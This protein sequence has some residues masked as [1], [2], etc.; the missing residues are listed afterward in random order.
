MSVGVLEA[1]NR[2][3]DDQPLDPV[4]PP[5]IVITQQPGAQTITSGQKAT[6]AVVAEGNGLTYQWQRNGTRDY[7]GWSGGWVNVTSPGEGTGVTT[8]TYETEAVSNLYNGIQHRVIVREAGGTTL[9]SQ[10]VGL[11]VSPSGPVPTVPGVPTLTQIS[12]TSVHAVWSPSTITAGT[13][14]YIA[15]MSYSPLPD[16]GV[17]NVNAGMTNPNV[18]FTNIPYPTHSTFYVWVRAVSNVGGGYNYS[19]WSGARSITITP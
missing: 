18:T 12:T 5:P 19:D 2:I 11:T 16:T 14:Y 7:F 3:A 6:F 4:K 9:T 1:A 17:T 13:F 15:L 8:A 10:I